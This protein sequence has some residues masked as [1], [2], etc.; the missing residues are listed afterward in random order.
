MG[1]E[2]DF[3]NWANEKV[4]HHRVPVRFSLSI[5]TYGERENI[6][7]VDAKYSK[8][9]TTTVKCLNTLMYTNTHT[10]THTVCVHNTLYYVSIN[11]CICDRLWEN[12][13]YG[14]FCENR[15]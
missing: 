6:N 10:H 2:F 3:Y 14:I 1:F 7:I 15:V 11:I 5:C 8:S 12:P 9:S 13:A 4:L